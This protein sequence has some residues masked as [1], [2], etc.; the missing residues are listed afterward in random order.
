MSSPEELAEACELACWA[1]GQHDVTMHESRGLREEMTVLPILDAIG[2]H[3]GRRERDQAD[4]HVW[5]LL[6]AG[7][8]CA[9][10]VT[11]PLGTLRQRTRRRGRQDK[12][13][14]STSR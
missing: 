11:Q 1:L 6:D 13:P 5:W 9:I 3:S 12:Q 14:D 8:P 7:R 4:H 10:M 2:F